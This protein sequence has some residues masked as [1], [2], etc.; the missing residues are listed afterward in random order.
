DNCCLRWTMIA[1][2]MALTPDALNKIGS[3]GRSLNMQDIAW[4]RIKRTLSFGVL[5]ASLVAAT[6]AGAEPKTISLG[7]SGG[8][9]LPNGPALAAE[10]DFEQVAQKFGATVDYRNFGTGIDSLSALMTG[11]INW[12]VTGA[13]EVV[14]A[15]TAQRDMVAVFNLYQGGAVV[16]VGAKKYEA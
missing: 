11:A 6:A 14:K 13:T 4:R 2:L 8:E 12:V 3:P 1:R 15:S 10:P 16:L 7:F 5:A 9:V